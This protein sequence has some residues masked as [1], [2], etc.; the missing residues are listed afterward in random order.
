MPTKR[1][2]ISISPDAE[3]LA[4]LGLDQT[5]DGDV[6]GAALADSVRRYADLFGEAANELARVFLPPVWEFLADVLRHT[7]FPADADGDLPAHLAVIDALQFAHRQ[8]RAA[9]RLLTI[10]DRE[11]LNHGAAMDKADAK[12]R[13]IVE[14]LRGLTAVHGAAVLAA[15]RWYWS[16]QD[17]RETQRGSWWLPSERKKWFRQREAERQKKQAAEKPPE[18]KPPANPNQPSLFDPDSEEVA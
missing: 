14:T 2:R 6:T 1:K 17:E 12:L 8:R 9:D 10:R 3:S 15:V 4:A 11:F 16:H 7:K 18:Q 5:I 13:E